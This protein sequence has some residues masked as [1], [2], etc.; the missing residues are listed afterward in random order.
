MEVILF[1]GDEI[2][3]VNGESL[4]GLTHQE[5]TIRFKQLRKGP[6]T[7]MYKRPLPSPACRW[8]TL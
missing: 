2:V 6:V 1:L 5:A 8:V 3:E 7:L 4:Q